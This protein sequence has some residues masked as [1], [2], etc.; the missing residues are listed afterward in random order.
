LFKKRISFQVRM[1]ALLGH[2]SR[3]IHCTR[4][5][6]LTDELSRLCGDINTKVVIISCL[7]GSLVGLATGSSEIPKNIEKAMGTLGTVIRELARTNIALRIIVAP[8]TPRNIPEFKDHA[9]HALVS[10]I[11][12]RLFK[13]LI[14]YLFQFIPEILGGRGEGVRER[15]RI[16]L[17]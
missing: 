15:F 1:E 2:Q 12:L 16:K 11:S 7:T 10:R 17:G 8:C 9:N 4:F 14:A 5:T 13:D 3:F 6:G